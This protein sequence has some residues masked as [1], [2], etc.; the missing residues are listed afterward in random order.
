MSFVLDWIETL[1]V[2]HGAALSPGARNEKLEVRSLWV[3]I[4]HIRAMEYDQLATKC[5]CFVKA[6]QRAFTSPGTVVIKS[7]YS[8]E[9]SATT[10]LMSL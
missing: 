7:Q 1:A 5:H 10:S 3:L 2:V 9:V 4:T 8:N 6:E